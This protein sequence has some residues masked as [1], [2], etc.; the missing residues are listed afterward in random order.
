MTCSRPTRRSAS[1]TGPRSSTRARPLSLFFGDFGHQ[2]LGNKADVSDA[3]VARENAWLDFYVKG[4]GS[5]PSAGRDRVHPDLPEH[6]RDAVGGPVHGQQ[7]GDHRA[8]RVAPDRRRPRRPSA[9]TG[10]STRSAPTFDPG[11]ASRATRL[12]L[13]DHGGRRRA[14]HRQLLACPAVTEPTTLMGV[15]DGDRRHRLRLA[16][17]TGWP[18]AC[19]T[20][21]PDG[22]GAAGRARPLQA[23]AGDLPPGVPAPPERLHVPARERPEARAARQGL[24]GA[25]ADHLRPPAE[26][27]GRHHRRATSRCACR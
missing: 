3:L 26:R 10:G 21:L 11:L 18:P 19:S 27:P 23:R 24:G 5:A 6:L 20:S 7:L 2:R 15:D 22:T 25:T 16:P 14:R 8:R 4:T 13:R 12:R 9:P 17:T 1:T